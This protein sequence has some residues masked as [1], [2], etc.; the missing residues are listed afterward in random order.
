MDD[1]LDS[2][3]SSHSHNASGSG[4][5]GL[6]LVLPSLKTVQAL[7]NKKSRKSLTSPYDDGKVQKIPRPPKLK[8]L[9][10]VLTKL[11]AQIKKK[12]DYAFFLQ[13]VDVSQVPGYMD[14][15]QRPMDLGTMS[16]KIQRGRYRSLEEFADDIRLV[17]TNA[18][19]FNPPGTIY[20]TEAEK[21]EAFALEHIAKASAS[22]IEYET[23]WNIE[24]EGDHEAQDN[25]TPM[26][27]DDRA[28]TASAPTPATAS[29]IAHPR[30]RAAAAAGTRKLPGALS[31]TLEDDGGLPGA[32]DGLGAFPPGSDWAELMLALK[33]RGKRHRTKKE[34]LRMEKG[35]PPYRA[36]GSLDYAEL[37]NPFSVL[38]FF[39]PE[40]PS[41]P[42][43]TPLFP[44][45]RPSD[46]PG[47]PYPS[48]VNL[49]AS[50]TAPVP[51]PSTLKISAR[52]RTRATRRH[53]TIIRNAPARSRA[54]ERDNEGESPPGREPAA[55]DFGVYAT[56]MGE[57]AKQRQVKDIAKEFN[58]EEK[59][60]EAIRESIEAS[61]AEGYPMDV[62][63]GGA[64]GAGE[65]Y[66]RGK[67][68]EAEEYLRDVVY[69][70]VDGLAY[71][72]SLAEFVRP[73][74]DLEETRKPLN[75]ALG[76]PLAAYVDTHILEPLT[77]GRHRLL[78]E[79]ARRL[80]DPAFHASPQVLLQLSLSAHLYPHIAHNLSQ[81]QAALG[82][83]IDM[84]PLI[85]APEE[86]YRVEEAWDGRAVMEARRQAEE[87][88]RAAG[89]GSAMEYLQYAIEQNQEGVTA[90]TEVQEDAALLQYI[91]DRSADAID[92]IA[93]RRGAPDSAKVENSTEGATSEPA[94][95][96]ESGEDE[97][98]R[99]RQLRL[100]LLALAKRAPLDQIAKLPPEL[101]PERLRTVVPTMDS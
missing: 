22:V 80:D 95:K 31:E 54:R 2:P 24:I 29:T 35:G 76:M 58:S 38:S 90:G 3:S 65:E 93:R 19:T 63:M 23:D 39:A 64:E 49:P 82:V 40:Y 16:H 68:A 10:E 43:L 62:Q 73:P 86:L 67:D 92:E 46:R 6:R 91:L 1:A 87:E 78:C 59:V 47:A 18:K 4:G 37:D 33:L 96:T 53:W 88:E 94:T 72:R 99:M 44:S 56:L 52:S 97:D 74:E 75:K 77:G 11:I 45:F 12:D 36:D 81:L 30:R 27:V 70:G 85:R 66:W 13:P 42:L 60:C 50:P 83:Q 28:S 48:P 89:A 55:V 21:I 17:T 9:K 7:K 57:L 101:V 5:S 69:G 26:D 25:R 20:Y 61:T 98:P 34:R 100:N 32:K 41:R 15:I 84:T 8:P 71:V 14:V 51:V 79:A